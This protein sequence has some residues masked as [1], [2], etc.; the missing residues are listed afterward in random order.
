MG[1]RAHVFLC[2]H[3]HTDG[4]NTQA[5]DHAG[6]ARRSRPRAAL[7]LD[8]AQV[9]RV[10]ASPCSNRSTLARW[11]LA[12]SS[13]CTMNSSC[14]TDAITKTKRGRRLVPVPARA[15]VCLPNPTGGQPSASW[16]SFCSSSVRVGYPHPAHPNCGFRKCTGTVG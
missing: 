12:H 9:E 10:A 7:G 8:I 11:D 4:G 15:W 6:A 13:T 1:T 2:T 16:F 5:S 14:I 3:T